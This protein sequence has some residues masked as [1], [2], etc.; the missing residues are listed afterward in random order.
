MRER[1]RETET[2]E[3]LS[4]ICWKF[5]MFFCCDSIAFTINNDVCENQMQARIGGCASDGANKGRAKE[6]R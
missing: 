4:F 3:V 5:L 2:E 1:D 6:G